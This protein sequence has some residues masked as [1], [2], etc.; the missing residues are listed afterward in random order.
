MTYAHPDFHQFECEICHKVLSSRQNYRQHQHIHTGARPFLCEICGGGYRQGSQLAIHRRKHFFQ[1]RSFPIFKLTDLLNS[2]PF[3]SE[4]ISQDQ[5]QS[6]AWGE[7]V[8]PELV[9]AKGEDM[10]KLPC[11]G[12]QV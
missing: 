5:A 8:L 9:E 6:T 1:V 7:V 2:A 11:L 10:V 4:P 3:P 12:S